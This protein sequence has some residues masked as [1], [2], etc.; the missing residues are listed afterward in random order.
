M[1][2]KLPMR[3]VGHFGGSDVTNWEGEEQLDGAGCCG[4][5]G[6]RKMESLR[7]KTTKLYKIY[8]SVLYPSQMKFYEGL[9]LHLMIRF[10]F[11]LG[12]T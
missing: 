1:T 6:E 10:P 5:D 11:T 4:E 7:N 2:G 12:T 8:K 9:S 3:E